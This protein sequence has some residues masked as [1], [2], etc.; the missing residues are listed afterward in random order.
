MGSIYP[1]YFGL[2]R[3]PAAKPE[4]EE[5]AVTAQEIYEALCKGIA[6]P[7][8]TC[9]T[10][11]AGDPGRQVKKA[12]VAMFATVDLIREVT[13]WGADLLIVHEPTYYNHLDK[14]IESAVAE[15]KRALLEESG[16]VIFRYHDHPHLAA[17]DM[18]C[19]GGLAAMGLTGKV[20]KT[21]NFGTYLFTPDTPI[22]AREAAGR[23]AERQG[24]QF[25][26]VTGELD[27]PTR[28]IAVCFGTP[29]H[30]DEAVEDDR[31]DLIMTGEICEWGTAERVRD[32]AALGLHKSLMVMGHI[33]SERDGMK[34]VA[35]QM[36]T[37]FPEIETAYFECGE[38]FRAL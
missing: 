9:D 16:L 30:L 29:G 15:R 12:A 27:Y 25:V 10:F 26:R 36:K 38:V 2:F 35:E 8:E 11:K 19:K 14:R 6:V 24:L 20:E 34:Y 18:I 1:N 3:R 5:S 21:E 7:P 13:A 28:R 23:M 31:F 22:T 4:Q 37:A 32:A 33:G 17:E